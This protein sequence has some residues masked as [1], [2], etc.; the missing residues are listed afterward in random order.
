[1]EPSENEAKLVITD[2]SKTAKQLFNSPARYRRSSRAHSGANV[3]ETEERVLK[4]IDEDALI[5]LLQDMVEIPTVNP[6]GN[7]KPCAEFIAIKMRE[8]GFSKVRIMEVVKNRANVVGW[9]H[10]AEQHPLLMLEGH[11]D[12]TP[13]SDIERKEWNSDPFS[14]NIRE[15]R[16]YGKGALDDKSGLAAALIALK[17]IKDAGVRT[18]GSVLFAGLVDEE[19]WMLGVKHLIKSGLT[20]DVDGCL[21]VDGFWGIQTTCGGS[22]SLDITAIGQSAHAGLHPSASIGINAIY[23][24]NKL[25][26]AL[27][28]KRPRSHRHPVFRNSWWQVLRI[29][30]GCLTYPGAVLPDTCRI[31][32]EGKLVPGHKCEDLIEDVE[33]IIKRL[34]AADPGFKAVVNIIE[35]RHPY[36][37]PRHQKIVTAL[38]RSYQQVVGKPPLLNPLR[39][40]M[41]AT[42]DTN[43][44][45]LEGI[46]C[47][48]LRAGPDPKEYAGHKANEFVPID[49]L[50]AC[51]KIYALAIIRYAGCENP[52]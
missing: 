16:I 6:P 45:S 51:A 38:R 25:V 1:M 35:T 52:N 7:E 20:E 36:E 49:R 50:I 10:G 34:E 48:S 14:A 22:L 15:G 12:T 11:M 27:Q 26:R 2:I 19:S 40:P 32:L 42:F 37:T 17:A 33:K 30:G 9:I 18:K 4:C 24:M 3:L 39:Y 47:V 21:S 28:K 23:K 44:I 31:T 29:E 5:K 43:Y 41:N 46:P 8:I 13:V